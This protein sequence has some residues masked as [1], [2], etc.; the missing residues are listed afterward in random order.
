MSEQTNKEGWKNAFAVILLIVSLITALYVLQVTYLWDWFNPLTRRMAAWPVF[1]PHVEMYRFGREEWRVAQMHQRELDLQRMELNARLER[2]E[3]EE[4]ALARRRNELQ[5]EEARLAE[6]ET[7][8]NEREAALEQAYAEAEALRQLRDFYAA[9]RPADA[10]AILI[11]LQVD[12]IALVLTDMPPR[13]AGSILAAL[14]RDT[15]AAVS[16]AMGL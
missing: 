12:E 14:P 7:S 3:E 16:K 11:D 10:A 5:F 1:A 6:W 2:L 13:Q 8:L 15:A 4:K 9:M